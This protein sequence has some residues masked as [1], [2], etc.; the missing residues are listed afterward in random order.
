MSYLLRNCSWFIL[1][2]NIP[3]RQD[4]NQTKLKHLEKVGQS[5]DQYILK[6]QAVSRTLVR[7]I[8]TIAARRVA[9]SRIRVS[10]AK[11]AAANWKPVFALSS[12]TRFYS[13]GHHKLSES[14][15]TERVLNVVKGFEKVDPAKV[16][17]KSHFL[18]D[19]GLDSLDAVEVVMALEEEF[20]IEIPDSEAE[21]IQS[22]ADAVNYIV[23][24]PQAK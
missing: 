10:K 2:S 4:A 18:N 11:V 17:A 12:Q 24:H 9:A 7:G 15:V 22:V 1:W 20:V 14:E 13:A 6:M 19:L 21:K 5:W 8:A 16:S 23:T 3:S